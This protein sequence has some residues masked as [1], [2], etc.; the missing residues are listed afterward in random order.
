MSPVV[1]IGIVIAVVIIVALVA[2]RRASTP[3][4]A[5]K[6]P[7]VSTWTVTEVTKET[8]TTV[9]FGVDATLGFEAGQ[10]VLLRPNAA[11]PW[12]A[13]S[14][15]RAPGQ[16]LRL[17][18]RRVEN[19]KVSTHLTTQLMTGDRL[20]V[21]G[22]YGQF[23]LPAIVTRGL[24][25]AGGSG[26]TPFLSWLHTLDGRGWPFPITL[27]VGNRNASEQILKAE[28][29]ALQAKSGGKLSCVHVTDD[30][31]GPL[32]RE[33]LTRLVASL[34]APSFMA[35]CGPQPMMDNAREVV[36]ARFP[37]V[38]VLEEKF[39][40]SVDA[41]GDG[42]GTT[43]ELVQDGKVKPFDVKPGEH[44]LAAARRAGYELP[45]GCEMGACG[46]CRV[47]LQSGDIQVPADACLSEKELQDG[48]RLICVGKA[49]G[50]ARFESAP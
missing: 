17:T 8:P 22:P 12:R 34:E 48:Y 1:I 2:S 37:G 42:P 10:F 4:A 39:S 16:P 23:V 33:L 31:E 27:I 3:A 41:V 20:E 21:K 49:R 15:S 7:A 9:S 47:K 40:A 6:A 26:I 35:M 28:L 44:V 38:A 50:P 24:F 43:L 19:G 30:R 46:A 36:S 5:G 25:I 45:S 13:Y 18:V 29:D 32:T 14:F 11:L